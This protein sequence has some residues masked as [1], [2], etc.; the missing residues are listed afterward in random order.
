MKTKRIAT[1]TD[2]TPKTVLLGV[3]TPYNRTKNV[4]S[5]YDEFV[6]LVRSNEMSHDEA[7]FMKLREINP[8]YFFTKGKLQEIKEFCQKNEIEQ[9]II[10]E[11][12]TSQQERNLSDYLNC[13]VSDRTQLIL[14]IFEKHAHSAEGKTQVEIAMLR[15]RKTRLA[16]RGIHM[17]QQS[18]VMGKIGGAGETAKEKETRYLNNKIVH[19]KKKLEKLKTVRETQR[20]T[21]FKNKVPHAC[22]IGY[23]NAGKSTILNLLTKSNVLAED[24]LFATLDTTTRALFIHGVKKGVISDSVGFI[25]QLPHNLIEA[26]KS[27]LDEL[28]YADLLLHVIDISDP[29]WESHTKIV[30]E[31]LEELGLQKD[32]LYIFNKTD[33]LSTAP[34]ILQQ[35][36]HSGQAIPTELGK[37]ILEQI[38]RYS[39]HV[40]ISAQSKDGIKNL[41]EYLGSWEVSK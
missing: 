7:L 39:P 30:H 34:S 1:A 35:A 22:L 29:N 4:Q 16:G 31:I 12:L 25:Q 11:P 14:E 5:Y 38:Q 2:H 6:N 18:G 36:Q 15:H 28:Q 27:T 41:V 40:L 13:E 24:K 23:T 17:S 9:L 3:Y 8:V 20:K 32:I 10:S 37:D 33:K 19:L 21:R 26:F